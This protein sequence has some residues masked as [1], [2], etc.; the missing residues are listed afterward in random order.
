MIQCL[1]NSDL[2]LKPLPVLYLF[3]ADCFAGSLL[4]REDVRA[5]SHGAIR[6]RSNDDLVNPIDFCE[7]LRVLLNHCCFLDEDGIFGAQ[8]G[9]FRG[10]HYFA[11]K[12]NEILIDSFRIV[13]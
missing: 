7:R 3:L 11:A 1:Q 12:I 4:L 9:R 10:V 8:L 2:G 5:P 6:S 13:H